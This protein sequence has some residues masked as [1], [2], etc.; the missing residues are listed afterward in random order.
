MN[1]TLQRLLAYIQIMAFIWQGGDL[2]IGLARPITRERL[3]GEI[4]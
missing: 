2:K 1:V 4:C 3:I